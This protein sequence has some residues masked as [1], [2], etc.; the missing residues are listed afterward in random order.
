MFSMCPNIHTGS[1]IKSQE[2]KISIIP[3]G[4][5]SEGARLQKARLKHVKSDQMIDI[6]SAL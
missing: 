5:P 6:A 4:L 2:K 1:V 3:I